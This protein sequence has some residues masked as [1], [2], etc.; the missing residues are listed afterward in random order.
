[1]HRRVDAP[2]APSSGHS[3]ECQGVFQLLLPRE[4]RQESESRRFPHAQL[5]KSVCAAL[6]IFEELGSVLGREFHVVETVDIGHAIDKP[7]VSNDAAE[8]FVLGRR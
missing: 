1:M 6:H 2:V 8:G 3:L 5:L 7:L 4:V